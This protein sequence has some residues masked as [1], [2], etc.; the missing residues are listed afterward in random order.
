MNPI[1][2]A[3]LPVAGLGTRFLPATKAMPKEMLPVSRPP[4]DRSTWSTRP[5]Q[6]GSCRRS[7]TSSRSRK[8]RW[9]VSTCTASSASAK[10]AA[11]PSR[12]PAL[13]EERPR[14]EAPWS[15]LI[16]TG[17]L[18]P[19][20]RDFD[21]LA[22]QTRGTGGE[23]QLT[24]AMIRLAEKQ[25]FYGLNFRAVSTAAARSVSSPPTSPMR[26]PARTSP[27]PSAQS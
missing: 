13:V 10:L 7:R 12:S 25:P 14:A 21:I 6:G 17:P 2:K 26:S 23:I 9:T 18:H 11:G 20:A 24:D 8:C 15:N 3:I 16:I 1:R 5:C 4:A 27:R 22:D 19:A